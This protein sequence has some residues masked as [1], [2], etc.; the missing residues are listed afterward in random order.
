L[1]QTG[2]WITCRDDAVSGSQG[3]G[4]GFGHSAFPKTGSHFSGLAAAPFRGFTLE[5]EN[6]I[7]PA[8]WH[9]ILVEAKQGMSHRKRGCRQ[10]ISYQERK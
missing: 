10:I 9:V 3:Q 6:R 8:G 1:A 2:P 7:R 5:L 4:R